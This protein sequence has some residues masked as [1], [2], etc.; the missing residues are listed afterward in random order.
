MSNYNLST[1]VRSIYVAADT[2][3]DDD[4]LYISSIAISV[5][6]MVYLVSET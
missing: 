5:F 2:G 6:G 4:K 3:Y 1:F